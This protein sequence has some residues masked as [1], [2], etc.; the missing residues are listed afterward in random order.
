MLI[1]LRTHVVIPIQ[2]NCEPHCHLH[3]N[4]KN[5]TGIIG[6]GMGIK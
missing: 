6:D 4:L 2:L 5:T 3:K 1:T